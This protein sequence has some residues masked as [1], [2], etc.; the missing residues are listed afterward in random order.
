[1]RAE[2]RE[3]LRWAVEKRRKGESF[4]TSLARQ[5]KGLGLGFDDYIRLI[6]DLR[7]LSREK[8]IDLDEASLE[9][10]SKE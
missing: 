2:E 9:L 8:G 7:D 10:A 6:A 4:E 5:V 3:A 1:M